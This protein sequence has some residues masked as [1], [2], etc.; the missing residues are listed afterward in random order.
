LGR[1]P[2]DQELAE[3]M[4]ISAARISQMRMAAIAPTSLDAAIGEDDSTNFGEMV[5][6]EN[7]DTPYEMLSEKASTGMLRSM[8]KSLSPREAV[9]LSARF[10]LD[11]EAP[12]K[13]DDIGQQFGITRERVRQLQN[14]ALRKL[15]KMIE[16]IERR[17]G[18]RSGQNGSETP[19]AL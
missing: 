14:S 10:G 4:G 3:D 6:D 8:V 12:K 15:R 5:A 2:T 9:I 1:E 19:E 7:A 13:L 18:N 16:R 11:G 17:G